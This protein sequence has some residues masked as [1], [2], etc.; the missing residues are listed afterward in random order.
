MVRERLDLYTRVE[1]ADI[2]NAVILVS[3]HTSV[4]RPMPVRDLTRNGIDYKGDVIYAQDLGYENAKLL[5]FY[6]DRSFYKYIRDPDKVEGQMI[7]L[8]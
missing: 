4:I 3:T 1:N 5:E 2:S 8:R 7:K 6:P